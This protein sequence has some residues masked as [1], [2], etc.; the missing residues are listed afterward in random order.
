MGGS[1][2]TATSSRHNRIATILVVDDLSANRAFLGALLREQGHRLLEAADGAQGLAAAQAERPD[3]VITDVLMPVMDGFEF[4][5]QLRLDPATSGTPV[6]L[7]TAT[8]SARDARD[9]AHSIGAS[10]VLTKPAKAEEVLA[11]VGRAL[12]GGSGQGELP[13][14]S[15]PTADADRE[16]LGLLSDRLSEKSGDLRSANARLRALI[17]IGLELASERDPERLLENVCLASRDLFGASYVTLGI[18]DLNDRTVVRVAT[19][20]M[21]ANAWIKPGDPVAGFFAQVIGER[22][23]FRGEYAGENAAGLQWPANHPEVRSFLAAPIASPGLVF[24]WICFV[25]NEGRAFTQDDE[26]L[27]MALSGQV[28]RIYEGSHF[29]ALAKK[30]AEEL[31][32]EILER[33]GVEEILRIERDRSQRYLDT[34]QVMLVA[35]DLRGKVTL[36]NRYACSVLGWTAEELRGVDWLETCIPARIRESTRGSFQK[37]LDGDL[38]I[39]ENPVLTRSG[40]ERLFQWRNTLIRNDGDQIVGVLSSGADITEHSLA[41]E[42]LR[43]AEER[44]RFAL[45]SANVGIWDMDYSSGKLRWSETLEAQYGLAPKSFT[46]T[47][48]AFIACIHPDDRTSVVAEVEAAI[49]A[50]SDFSVVHRASWPD[51]T[52]RWLNGIGRVRLDEQGRPVRA[53]GISMDV[54]GRRALEE[55]FHQAQKM[56]AIGRLAGGVAHD[57]NNLLTAILGYCELLL[58]DLDP[59]DPRRAD[60]E[61]IQGAGESAARL[62]RQ[63][64]AFS[65]RQIVEPTLLDLNAVVTGVHPILTRLIGE[66]VKIELGL[67]SGLST[68]K[69]DRGQVEQIILNLAVNARDAMPKGGTLSL[70]TANVELDENYP[71]THLSVRPGAYVALT[72]T[73]TGSGMTAAVQDRLFEPFF[74]TKE[75]G[76]GTGLGLATV[77]GIVNQIGGSINV[78]SELNRG[79]SF[80]VYFPS[81]ANEPAVEAPTPSK[82]PAHTGTQTVLVVE[83]AEGLRD[84]VRRLLERQGYTVLVA[85]NAD[86]AI[87]MFEATETIDVLLTDV[88][89]PGASGPE[90]T[91]RLIEKRP[92][93]RVIYMSGYTEEAIVQHG[94]LKPGIAFLHKPF[95]ADSLGRKIREVL[96]LELVPAGAP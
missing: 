92:G 96:E 16:Y 59:L 7:Y 84:L 46:G 53:I 63:L 20:G 37:L 87:Q 69:A 23:T 89:M 86:D 27:V 19:S 82:G 56:E 6:V 61:E 48:E 35:L 83:D 74:T 71:K 4:V 79:T 54:T 28:G 29:F 58:T 72:V 49:Q 15:Q 39:V 57:F 33:N 76:R 60:I 43:T 51:G 9:L 8:Y 44:M 75:V 78:Y 31:E 2:C 77:H 70:E 47:F 13:E 5:R 21:D 24:G 10:Y 65:R 50:G 95:T 80:K 26:D 68:V 3:L 91:R 64:L 88:V 66:D 34:A 1:S 38:S 36:A 17:N 52:I 90:L 73:D 32:G 14:P 22:R 40:E 85:S 42:A 67:Q 45:E 62:T 30:R 41:V 94:V 55:Q 81:A 18:V 12:A 11:V 93:L 25:G